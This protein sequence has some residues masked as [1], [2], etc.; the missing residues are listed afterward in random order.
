MFARTACMALV[1]VE[2]A[3]VRPTTK[4]SSCD[5]PISLAKHVKARQNHPSYAAQR[6]QVAD[7]QVL[8]DEPYDG[9]A[10]TDYTHEKLAKNPVWADPAQISRVDWSEKHSSY[11]SRHQC[12]LRTLAQ[13]QLGRPA[14]TCFASEVADEMLGT[15]QWAIPSAGALPKNYMGRTGMTGRGSLGKWGAN[16][17]ADPVVTRCQAGKFQV[18]LIERKDTLT[19]A[20]PGGMVDPGEKASAAA[21]REFKE[22]A[23]GDASKLAALQDAFRG[24][25]LI[26]T[27]Y[28]DDPRNTD[29]AW[30]ETAA[31]HFHND[32]VFG[33][34][35]LIAGDDAG[36]AQWVTIEGVEDTG[37][38]CKVVLEESLAQSSIYTSTHEDFIRIAYKYAHDNKLCQ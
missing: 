38:S 20:I 15:G 14:A 12:G 19:W 6:A 37:N 25:T 8:W 2:I 28:V 16:Q 33:T 4:S 31:F 10:P 22:E 23:G 29:N 13:A 21:Q 36:K 17:A 5:L 24:G 26:Y 3:A 27:G 7:N 32:S 11:W 9:Y 1:A 30:M 34:Y 35:S 18:A